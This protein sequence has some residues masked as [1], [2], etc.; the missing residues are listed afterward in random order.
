MKAHVIHAMATILWNNTDTPYPTLGQLFQSMLGK[1]AKHSRK[2]L[3][4]LLEDVKVN[5]ME[6]I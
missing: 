5:Y 3:E 2:D 6:V 1:Y 4:R